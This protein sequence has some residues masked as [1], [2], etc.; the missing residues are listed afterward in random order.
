MEPGTLKPQYMTLIL[1]NSVLSTLEE[2]EATVQSVTRRYIQTVDQWL[3]MISRRKYEKELAL[4]STFTSSENFLLLVLAQHLVITPTED[5]PQTDDLSASPW[6]KTCKYN[7]S[8]F[9]AFGE[10]TIE[11]IQMGMLISL[12]EYTHC[13]G[14]QQALI[15][16]GT[17]ARLAYLLEFDEVMHKHSTQDLGKL[18][19]ED[20]EVS[21]SNTNV[22]NCNGK[23]TLNQI[24]LTWMGL[25][26]LDRYFNMP[27]LAIPKRHCMQ[28]HTE[29]NE[30]DNIRPYAGPLI[31]NYTTLD[32]ETIQSCIYEYDAAQRLGRVQKFIRENRYAPFPAV[33]NKVKPMLEDIDKYLEVRA[34]QMAQDGGWA[35][36]HVVLR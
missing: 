13:I 31:Q 25:T 21:V 4:F 16:L 19:L 6:Y 29:S 2:H 36:T 26:R 5:H 23:L 33:V 34:A 8:Q 1:W 20:E 17:C 12:F 14:E 7:F 15:T 10:P 28:L 32:M 35:G 18:S 24:L 3:P 27:P 9:V 30:A 11:L 22:Q